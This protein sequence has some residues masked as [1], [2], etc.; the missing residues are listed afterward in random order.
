MERCERASILT[1]LFVLEVVL[2]NSYKHLHTPATICLKFLLEPEY[3]LVDVFRKIRL[4]NKHI[5]HNIFHKN[6]NLRSSIFKHII[7]QYE[8]AIVLLRAGD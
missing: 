6:E 5:D 3:Y 7:S 4:D 8:N 1:D 2:R